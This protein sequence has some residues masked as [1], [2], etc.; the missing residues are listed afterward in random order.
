MVYK[1]F[2][3]M[4]KKLSINFCKPLISSNFVVV[5]CT[6]LTFQQYMSAS[7]H[8][9]FQHVTPVD[10]FKKTPGQFPAM[11]VVTKNKYF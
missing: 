11:F 6:I 8:S 10:D 9:S 3:K 5:I 7:D 1:V 4:R 2:E